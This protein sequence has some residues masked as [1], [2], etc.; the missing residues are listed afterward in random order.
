VR[1]KRVQGALDACDVT[2]D[3][4]FS[5]RIFGVEENGICDRTR[6]DFLWDVGTHVVILEVDED[7][8][9]DRQEYCECV[10]MRNI[11]ESLMRPTIFI[12]YNPDGFKQEGRKVN[13]SHHKR[14]ERLTKWIQQLK[15]MSGSDLGSNKLSVLHLFY[16]DREGALEHVF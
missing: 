12:R 8:H 16:S 11:T 1:Q 6:P 13:L 5:D 10:R 7:Q 4:E 2:A 9:A 14:M 15:G 3:Y